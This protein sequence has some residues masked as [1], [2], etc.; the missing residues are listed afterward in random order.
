MSMIRKCNNPEPSCGGDECVG[1]NSFPLE[2]SCNGL[3]CPGKMMVLCFALQ[4]V[5]Y[6]ATNVISLYHIVYTAQVRF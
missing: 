1:S 4:Y 6:I 2:T 3:C 5:V